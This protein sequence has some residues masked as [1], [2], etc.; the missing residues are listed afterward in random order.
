MRFAGQGVRFGKGLIDPI[1][2]PAKSFFEDLRSADISSNSLIISH[3]GIAS[4]G[5]KEV[6]YEAA[7]C[8]QHMLLVHTR[9][10][11]VVCD[12]STMVQRLSRTHS[13]AG[14]PPRVLV[15]FIQQEAKQGSSFS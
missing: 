3:C 7:Q 8:S 2:G 9:V 14:T 1:L 4:H 12:S 13:E 10:A 15:C 6:D 11:L 5:V